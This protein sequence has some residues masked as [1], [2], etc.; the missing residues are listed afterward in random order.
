MKFYEMTSL[1]KYLTFFEGVE[2]IVLDLKLS[3]NGG[4]N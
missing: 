3:S 2:K 4:F 1:S